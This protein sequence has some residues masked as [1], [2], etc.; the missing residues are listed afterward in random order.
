MLILEPT[1]CSHATQAL[2][3]YSVNGERR[4]GHHAVP[5][6][7]VHCM[8]SE[9]FPS[10][11][12]D[13]PWYAAG[14]PDPYAIVEI[15]R[16]YVSV[17]FL[18][19][20][21]FTPEAALVIWNSQQD[22]KCR[23]C[24][25][26]RH[27]VSHIRDKAQGLHKTIIRQSWVDGLMALGVNQW[28]VWYILRGC[29]IASACNAGNGDP[30]PW[31]ERHIEHTAR[32]LDKLSVSLPVVHWVLTMRAQPGAAKTVG[33]SALKAIA[34]KT[35]LEEQPLGALPP[36]PS[37]E[38]GNQTRGDPQSYS[39]SGDGTSGGYYGPLETSEGGI[40]W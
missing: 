1:L 16:S 14:S 21:G 38:G 15:P 3:H 35:K 36:Q 40:E 13:N 5:N 4:S 30:T 18:I 10:E 11:F 19:F 33:A 34:L 20:V 9:M 6:I 37:D 23:A 27:I 32:F 8:L 24:D 28:F 12:L 39:R 31:L 17:E 29:S 25:F 2:S 26:R 22:A 7:L